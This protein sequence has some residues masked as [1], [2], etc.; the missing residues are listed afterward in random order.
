MVG[1]SRLHVQQIVDIVSGAIDAWLSTS[2]RRADVAAAGVQEGE[3][4]RSLSFVCVDSKLR[5]SMRDALI[6]AIV[7]IVAAAAFALVE[8][9]ARQAGSPLTAQTLHVVATPAA[10]T[11]SM[12]FWALKGQSRRVQA[13]VVIV[14]VCFATVIALV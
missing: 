14:T 2:S 4:M 1:S 7:L 11:L 9:V 6:G 13:A 3:A 10:V 5:Y 8:K 12:P